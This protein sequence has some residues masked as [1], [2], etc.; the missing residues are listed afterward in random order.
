MDWTGDDHYRFSGDYL[1]RVSESEKSEGF[2]NLS[3]HKKD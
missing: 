1:N 2:K 3:S